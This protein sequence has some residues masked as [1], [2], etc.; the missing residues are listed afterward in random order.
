[1]E[2]DAGELMIGE[3]RSFI[4]RDFPDLKIN[5]MRYLGSGWD[6]AAFL[7]N[8]EY[9]F[10]FLRGLFD[11]SH[12][13]KT[14][15]IKKEVNILT[16]LHDK[17]SFAVPKPEF[18]GQFFS[19]FGYKLVPGTL[20]D[21][22]DQPFAEEYLQSWVATRTEISKAIQPKDSQALMVPLYQT[23][24]N[25]RLVNA[26]LQ[27]K[28]SDERVKK[29]VKDAM[30]Y[31]LSKFTDTSKWVFIHEDLQMSNCMVDQQSKKIIGVVDWLE[32]EVGPV[33]AE[34]YFWSKYGHDML[35]KV[36]KIQQAFDGTVI[37]MSLAVAIHQ[38]YITA[39]YVD[40]KNRGY[41]EAAAHKWEQIEK[42]L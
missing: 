23:G 22:A 40:F 21:K 29:V 31:I 38:F 39:D 17:T 12:P 15:E 27:D 14:D 8:G 24:K 36:A 26:F 42:Y 4:E 3:Y 11:R 28:S 19:Y 2:I 6:N 41:E 30:D 32:A 1:M 35:E 33:E 13:L 7:V 25:E 5:E 34:F 18:I 9:V 10:R 16:Y 37:D 20:W